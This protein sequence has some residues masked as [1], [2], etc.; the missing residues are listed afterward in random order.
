MGPLSGIKIIELGGIGPVPFCAMVLA[1]MGATVIRVD[2]VEAAGTGNRAAEPLLR[3][4]TSVALNLKDPEGADLVLRLVRGADALIEGFRP[5]VVER[6]GLGPAECLEANPALVY[7][8]MTGWGREG[9]LAAAAGHDLNYVAL[10]GVLGMIGPAGG[11]PSVP[12]NVIADFGGGGML[13]AL[14]VLAAVLES[15]SSGRGQ[16]VDAAMVDGAALLSTMIHGFR[17]QGLWTDQREANLLDGGAP[18]YGVYETADGEYLTIASI[19]PA[20]FGELIERLGLTGEVPGQFDRLR[21]PE[22]RRLLEETFA[23]R[24]LAEWQAALEGTDVCFAPVL[25]VEEA[26]SHPHNLRRHT[27]IEVAAVRQ[28]AP[29]PRFSRTRSEEPTPPAEAGADTAGVLAGLGLSAEE[30]AGL[31]ERQVIA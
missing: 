9:P 29:A 24:T 21:W 11:A 14:G 8:R 12:L 20:F 2:R 31:R 7:G 3:N 26:A 4:R 22:L 27:F 17:A 23:T 5:G 30:I 25:S 19:E 15:R 18:F 13:L 6:L 1:D 16:V 28:P 10:A